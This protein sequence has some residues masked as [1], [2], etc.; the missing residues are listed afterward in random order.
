MS[1][2]HVFG[3]VIT[4]H[5][6]VITE[7][8]STSLSVTYDGTALTVTPIII[9]AIDAWMIDAVPNITLVNPS[10]NDMATFLFR[11]AS[12]SVAINGSKPKLL[13]AGDQAFS[14]LET[15]FASNSPEA[16]ENARCRVRTCDFLRVKQALYH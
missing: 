6:L 5:Q 16:A 1:D 2:Q 12:A 11:A 15:A 4:D 7:N 13:T 3:S 9:G 10:P 8:S 14:P